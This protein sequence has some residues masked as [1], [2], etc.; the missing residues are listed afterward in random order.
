M[1]DYAINVV[2]GLDRPMIRF[3]ML[4]LLYRFH[5]AACLDQRDRIA[6]LFGLVSRECWF[7]MDYSVHWTEMYRQAAEFVLKGGEKDTRLYPDSGN[8]YLTQPGY[9]SISVLAFERDSFKVHWDPALAGRDG[10]RVAWIKHLGRHSFDKDQVTD[11]VLKISYGLEVTQTSS[12]QHILDKDQ[13]AD[14]ILKILC[15][16]FPPIKVSIP[17]LLV[18]CSLIET[19]IRF[20]YTKAHHSN[21]IKTDAFDEYLGYFQHELP[22]A[23]SPETLDS[24]NSWGPT[25]R[26]RGWRQRPWLPLFSGPSSSTSSATSSSLPA[27]IPGP[28]LAR[29]TSLYALALDLSGHRAATVAALHKRYGPIVRLGPTELSFTSRSAVRALCSSAATVE[30]TPLYKSFGRR[31]MFQ[32]RGNAENRERKRRVGHI[33]SA[34]SLGQMEGVL[35][36]LIGKLV[37]VLKRE[38]SDKGTQAVDGLW[39]CRVMALE[40]AGEVLMGRGLGALDDQKDLIRERMEHPDN[41]FIVWKI[42][43]VA[44]ALAW[45]LDRLVP[46][47]WVK[48]FMAA[49]DCL[50]GYGGDAARE[51][52]ERERRGHSESTSR[53]TLLT[54]LVVGNPETGAE[55]LPDED[56]ATE[57]SGITF[58][59]VDATG[60]STA[61]MLYELA[62]HPEWQR[63]LQREIRTLV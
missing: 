8:E 9:P 7:P 25:S 5:A 59:T 29:F 46:G 33:F 58:A 24:E 51:Y 23:E 44:L 60:T 2:A 15:K 41:V 43:E 47:K 11:E 4:E 50:Y 20:S 54:K 61:Y 32:M 28:F 53:R 22:E 49:G 37:D 36:G 27:S 48:E 21:P 18:F 6:A 63:R 35:Q 14:E 17:H 57:V 16:F 40:A 34:A 38:S 39:W 13:M 3:S 12:S 1:F 45:V 10:R 62:C 56:I 30:K 19:L 52:L 42:W 55:P 31:G 26:R